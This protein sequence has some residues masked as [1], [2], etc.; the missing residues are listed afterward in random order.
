[1]L[2]EGGSG[3]TSMAAH[4]RECLFDRRGEERRGAVGLGV[5]RRR[6]QAACAACSA[7]ANLRHV[8]RERA[9]LVQSSRDVRHLQCKGE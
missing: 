7:G 8:R 9:Q 1:M 2:R 6:V 3:V 5:C 4:M